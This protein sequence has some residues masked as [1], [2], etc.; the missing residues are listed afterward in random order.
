MEFDIERSSLSY[1][2]SLMAQENTK[3]NQVTILILGT[4]KSEKK[5]ILSTIGSFS[6]IRII[7]KHEKTLLNIPAWPMLALLVTYLVLRATH[8]FYREPD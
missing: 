8:M 1:P 4:I 3:R 5:D 2:E 7:D 6:L